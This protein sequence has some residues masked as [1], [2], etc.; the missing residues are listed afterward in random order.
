MYFY[1]GKW[2][3][4]KIIKAS[5]GHNWILLSRWQSRDCTATSMCNS[6]KKKNKKKKYGNQRIYSL[7]TTFEMLHIN[8]VLFLVNKKRRPCLHATSQMLRINM[9]FEEDKK[10]ARRARPD[11]PDGSISMG[12]TKGKSISCI[13]PLWV[14]HYEKIRNQWK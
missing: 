3:G 10:E 7:G 5:Q 8:M 14:K 4:E 2:V 9:V 12:R 6:K 13:G 1:L 11:G